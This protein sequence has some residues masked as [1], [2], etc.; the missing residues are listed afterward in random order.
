MPFDLSK[1]PYFQPWADGETGVESFILTRR[2]APFQKA[3]YY[4]T[5]SI[6]A[7]GRW[8]WFRGIFPPTRSSILAAVC[9]DP[10]DPRIRLFPACALR[11]NPL[12]TPAGDAVY[13]PVHDGIYLQP[14]DGEPREIVRM[15]AEIVQ[16]RHLWNVVV[17]LT[18]SADGKHFLLDSHIGN[19]WLI[20]LA[21]VASA[22]VRPL[23]WFARCHHHAVFSPVDPDLFLVGQG[24]WHDPITGD[25]FDMN[26]RMWLM[27]TRLTRYEPLFGDLW[28]NHNC[29]SCHE[30]WSADGLV[31]WCDYNDGIYECDLADRKRVLVWPR[32][33][34]HGQCDPARRFYCGDQ[35]PYEP[36]ADNPCRVFFFDRRSGRDVA[37]ASNVGFPP[38]P[39]QDWRS[40]HLDPHPH[41]SADGRQVVYT[42]MVRG[43]PDVAIAP[44]EGI[45][46]KLG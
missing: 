27:D 21:D 16:N 43:V 26:I 39:R 33:L 42:T 13:A 1:H 5:P 31:C 35:N 36:T 34:W 7:D 44:V 15:P 46:D 32:P 3:A 14:F 37:I 29:M 6:S 24:P 28:F 11:G 22:R 30:W 2:V 38:L 18:V 10:A 20:S 8:L 9:L 12:L 41:F 4:A 40:Y 25:K 17:D 19:R 45:L 23:R